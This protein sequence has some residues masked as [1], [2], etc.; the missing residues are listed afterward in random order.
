VPDNTVTLVKSLIL[1]NASMNATLVNMLLN[2]GGLWAFA[3]QQ[4]TLE[5]NTR[6]LEEAWFVLNPG[7]SV[8]FSTEQADTYVWVSGAVLLGPP[9]FPPAATQLP[10]VKP[11]R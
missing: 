1:V 10:A 7:D 2:N 6:V 9:P 8:S 11:D 3:A 5:A 4:W